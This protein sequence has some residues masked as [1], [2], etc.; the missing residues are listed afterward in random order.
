MPTLAKHSLL[1]L[2]GNKRDM[3]FFKTKIW[4]NFRFWWKIMFLLPKTTFS[5]F[6]LFVFTKCTCNDVVLNSV[7]FPFLLWNVIQNVHCVCVYYFC[8]IFRVCIVVKKCAVFMLLLSFEGLNQSFFCRY[9]NNWGFFLL[10]SLYKS[11]VIVV[12]FVC[13]IK[14]GFNFYF[15]NWYSPRAGPGVKRIGLQQR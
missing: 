1:L 6:L 3:F 15:D 10:E 8:S 13:W 2:D 4:L 9:W 7:R 14:Y 12:N 11:V 5:F